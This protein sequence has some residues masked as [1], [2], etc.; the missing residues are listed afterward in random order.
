MIQLKYQFWKNVT[1]EK[2]NS[3]QLNTFQHICPHFWAWLPFSN[4]CAKNHHDLLLFFWHKNK[5]MANGNH[6][7]K[8][9]QICWK[10]F[11]CPEFHSNGNVYLSNW[12]F[13]GRPLVP[14]IHIFALYLQMEMFPLSSAYDKS[15]TVPLSQ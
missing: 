6:A 13:S 9:G 8:W 12:Y 15:W 5:K 4:S 11:N 1:S 7:Q 3:E 10:V 2:W 14:K